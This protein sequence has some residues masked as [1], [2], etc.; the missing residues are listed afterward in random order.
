MNK[1]QK[2]ARKKITVK[3]D[4]STEKPSD[5]KESQNS[6]ERKGVLPEGMDF[7]KFLGCGG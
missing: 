4:K 7:K 3:E 5:H 2:K 6:D 1:E